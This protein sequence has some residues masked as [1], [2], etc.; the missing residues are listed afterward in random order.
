MFHGYQ[1]YQ[2]YVYKGPT[3]LISLSWTSTNQIGT[4]RASFNTN[5]PTTTFVEEYPNVTQTNSTLKIAI[6]SLIDNK[7]HFKKIHEA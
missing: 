1:I 3:I 2:I 7:L 5:H 6:E 4:S